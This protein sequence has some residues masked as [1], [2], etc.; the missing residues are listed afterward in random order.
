[1]RKNHLK[2]ATALSLVLTGLTGLSLSGPALAATTIS[3][4]TTAPVAT[5]T[6]GDLTLD[7]A[8]SITLTTGTAVTVDSDNSVTI[9]GPINM[10][11]SADNSTGV[12]ISGGHTGN[13]TVAGNITVT[14]DYQATDTLP[15]GALDTIPDYPFAT[16]TARYGIH[17]AGT[18][19]F[20][21]NVSVASGS[22]ITVNGN[23]SYGIRFENNLN[24]IFVN[25]GSVVLIGDSG[26][27]ISLEKGATGVVNIS[28]T[29]SVQGKDSKGVFLGGDYGSN[30]I[31]DGSI[32]G[33]GYA[34]TAPTSVLTAAQI[35]AL[36]ASDLYQSGALVTIAGNFAH[37]VIIGAVPTTDSTSTSTDQ[38][39]D[40][41]TDST[42]S[43]ANLTQ[44]GSAPALLVGSTTGDIALSGNVYASTA[45]NPP[46]VSYG[47]LI[48]GQT[49]ALG[50]YANVDTHGIQ[51]GGTGHNVT[52]ANGIGIYGEQVAT[53]TEANATGLAILAGA[54]TPQLDI[55]AGTISTTATANATV[56]NTTAISVDIANGASLPTI[57]IAAGASIY[58]VGS[59]S[60]ASATAI[61]DQSNS[62]T[63]INNKNVINASITASDDNADGV[64]DTIT[65]RATAIDL[66]TNSVGVTLTQ[67]DTAPSDDTIAPPSIVGDIL[68]GSGNDTI[69]ENGGSIIGNIDFGAGAN[70]FTVTGSGTYL[71]QLTGT[72]TVALNIDAG[73]LALGSGTA[74]N[75]SSLHVGA[76]ST[77]GLTLD[78]D[79]PS[80]PI[81]TG[82][83]SAVFDNGATLSLALN[84]VLLAPTTF[85]VLQAGNI[86]LGTL[87]TDLDGHTPYIYHAALSTNTG[88]TQLL[89]NF[90]LKTQAE[91]AFSANE[92]AAL[93]PV[94]TAISQDTNAGA[95]A[96]LTAAITKDQFDSF[97]N[98]YLPDYSGENLLTLAR[99]AQ[100]LT[101]SLGSL[102]LVPDNQGGQYWLQ[103]Y[104]FKTTRKRGDTAGFDA[105]GF[106]FAGGRE[107][108]LTD[109]QMLGLLVSFASSTP[110]DSF[111]IAKE[112]LV[113][114][115]LTIGGYWRMHD[116]PFKAWAHVGAGFTHF[117]SD[118][119]LLTAYVNHV[120]TAKWNGY[121]YSG[122]FG[123]SYS[124][125]AGWL[126]VTPQAFADIY[127][128]N[129]AKHTETGGTDFFDLT[130]DSRNSNLASA[131]ALV[132]F[133]YNGFFVKPE[134]WLGYRSNLSAKIGNTVANFTN[135]GTP[136]T[137]TGGDITG[138]G[139]VAGF[140]LSTDNQ[141]SYFSLEGEYQK[142]D[143]YTDYSV[144]LRTRFQF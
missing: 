101:Q 45:V 6:T 23:N 81:F 64:A 74:L 124:Y 96:S 77:L 26:T 132:N 11:S 141:Y 16:G 86:S 142:L 47:L 98:E 112:D 35:A 105:T 80:T 12:L 15:T 10:S 136:F 58:A 67:T 120:A 115:D 21:G 103:E 102:T 106:A 94:L 100:A 139:P 29:V 126:N 79:H 123:A 42:Q 137:L 76:T 19:P 89:A 78:V 57:N 93:T 104:G 121:S 75:L 55:N 3:T 130:V 119:Q 140:R 117:E 88:G 133:A 125:R 113:N 84:K 40:G 116:G 87:S 97:Y 43:T 111:A 49:N 36:P 144:S 135:G 108:R 72:G 95:T 62:L 61:R 44:Y 4:A 8:G 5:S 131:S 83:G 73:T 51:I 60:T 46:A 39:G 32:S 109:T 41:L 127:G 22:V 118:R 91:G 2:S 24:G 7:T 129:E 50:T 53:S 17:S 65:H 138:G 1:M 66:H 63:T 90:R 18:T 28:G 92:Y 99:S 27:A 30:V 68:L 69:T 59:G 33:T 52:I 110:L 56:P 20:N 70:A 82:S 31:I 143:A 25:K 107:T 134:V 9:N 114:S 14:D 48:R 71:G 54:S 85:T 38:D 13:L 37:G 34:S 128:L 122:G